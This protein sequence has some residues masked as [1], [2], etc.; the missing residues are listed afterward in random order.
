MGGV[1]ADAGFGVWAVVEDAL[2]VH[3]GQADV[4]SHGFEA[5]CRFRPA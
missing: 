5:A 4:D 2:A 1:T 3:V